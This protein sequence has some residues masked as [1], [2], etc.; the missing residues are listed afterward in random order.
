MV[1]ECSLEPPKNRLKNIFYDQDKIRNICFSIRDKI[2]SSV[3]LSRNWGKWSESIFQNHGKS[4]KNKYCR[5]VLNIK[6]V[7]PWPEYF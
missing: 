2:S 3:S 4:G 1:N 7:L 5:W 6:E